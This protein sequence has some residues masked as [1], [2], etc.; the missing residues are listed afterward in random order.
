MATIG[1][2]FGDEMNDVAKLSNEQ[3][4]IVEKLSNRIETA[5]NDMA[6]TVEQNTAKHLAEIDKLV[7]R[8]EK[9]VEVLTKVKE[10]SGENLPVDLIPFVGRVDNWRDIEDLNRILTE[11]GEV[12]IFEDLTGKDT[13]DLMTLEEKLKDATD[14]ISEWMTSLLVDTVEEETRTEIEDMIKKDENGYITNYR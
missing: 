6:A 7:N 14:K 3:V 12:R 5:Y 4:N 2:D 10:I 1:R 11:R 8:Y 13:K 9:L